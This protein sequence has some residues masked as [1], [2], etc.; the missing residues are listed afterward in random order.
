MFLIPMAPFRLG[1]AAYLLLL[2]RTIVRASAVYSRPETPICSIMSLIC[3]KTRF[4]KALDGWTRTTSRSALGQK[5]KN[6]VVSLARVTHHSQILRAFS[7]GSFSHLSA[8][9]TRAEV[10][11]AA[12]ATPSSSAATGTAAE[13]EE[14]ADAAAREEPPPP[15]PPPFA[16]AASLSL[17]LRAR[18]VAY[19]GAPGTLPKSKG[20]RACSITKGN[21]FFM[22]SK[23]SSV[24]SGKPKHASSVQCP[25]AVSRLY[26]HH[27]KLST[28]VCAT[29]RQ[30]KSSKV[31]PRCQVMYSNQLVCG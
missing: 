23:N 10:R 27:I 29:Y 30:E 2:Q 28:K 5:L 7:A 3:E 21:S 31:D 22:P 13:D 11:I 19:S 4:T 25:E 26:Y 6:F 8:S 15:T 12:S 1:G 14:E 18:T 20:L 17:S 9:T 24:N 16:A